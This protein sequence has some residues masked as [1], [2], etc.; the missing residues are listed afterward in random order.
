MKVVGE[1]SWSWMLFDDDDELVLSVICGGAGV[2]DITFQLNDSESGQVRSHGFE[3]AAALAQAVRAD[4]AN[5][6]N[7]HLA[8]FDR[9]ADVAAA[10]TA[11]RSASHGRS[12]GILV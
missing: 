12:A 3:A 11:W 10:T 9:R 7:R 5:Y 6:L 1:E 8:E 2:Y 4:V